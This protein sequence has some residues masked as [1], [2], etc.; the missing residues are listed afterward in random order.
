VSH[1]PAAVRSTA[2]CARGSAVSTSVATR[3]LIVISMREALASLAVSTSR[4]AIRTQPLQSLALGAA[5]ACSIL[6]DLMPHLAAADVRRHTLR[7]H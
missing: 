3:C 4:S 5:K 7:H 2:H 6:P 1:F